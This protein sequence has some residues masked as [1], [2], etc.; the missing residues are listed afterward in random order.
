M[1]AA[2]I[3]EYMFI[4]VT[5]CE[6]IAKKLLLFTD[7]LY[8]TQVCGRLHHCLANFRTKLIFQNFPGPG[9][10]TNT[11]PGGD[12]TLI[13]AAHNDD[14]LCNSENYFP[15]FLSDTRHVCHQ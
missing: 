11:I 9:N 1:I 13:L 14:V 2:S 5:C 7:I 12:G 8:G 10:F 4:T 15:E 6:E 3:L